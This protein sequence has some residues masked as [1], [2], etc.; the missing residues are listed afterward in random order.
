MN[1]VSKQAY[2]RRPRWRKKETIVRVPAARPSIKQGWVHGL[3]SLFFG[4]PF[5]GEELITVESGQSKTA[6]K[7]YVVF[8]FFFPPSAVGIS[9]GNGF[10]KRFGQTR[11]TD[12]RRRLYRSGQSRSRDDDVRRSR[13]CASCGISYVFSR[14]LPRACQCRRAITVEVLGRDV[15]NQLSIPCLD[16]RLCVRFRRVRTHVPRNTTWSRWTWLTFP[17]VV[18]PCYADNLARI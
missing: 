10:E 12:K 7:L 1:Y 11:M 14:S 3:W 5:T 18:A 13:S 9:H 4:L 17:S 2:S 16:G 15:R 8:L 6:V